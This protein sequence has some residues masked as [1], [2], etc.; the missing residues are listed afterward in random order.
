M[1]VPLAWLREYVDLPDADAIVAR[2]ASLGFPVDEIETRP[3]LTNVVSGR[4]M[5]V[6]PHPNADRL[7]LCTIDTGDR[8]TLTI[9]T[10]ATNVAAGQLIPVARIGAQ[11]AG[12]LTIGPRKMRGVDSE[13][14]LCSAD[15]LGLPAE[16]FEDGIMQLDESVPPGTDVVAHF[17]L[18]E[19]VLDVDVTPNRPD[20]LAIV[21]LARELAAA[22][23]TA[24]REPPVDLTRGQ[25]AHDARV[26][27]ETVDCRRFVFARASGCA[28]RPDRRRCGFASRW[29]GS[30]RSTTSSTSRTS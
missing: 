3:A 4:I 13:G 5:T 24:L 18:G 6:G 12:G 29:P 10:A 28:S 25:P 9:A 30:V 26:T 16:W 8:A 2:L 14:M 21:G 27:I 23:G 7:Q 17:R 22:F 11:L 15:E 20:A 1:R 19:P